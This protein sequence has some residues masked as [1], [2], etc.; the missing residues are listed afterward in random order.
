MTPE[1]E[2]KLAALKGAYPAALAALYRIGLI[3]K[4]PTAA[5]R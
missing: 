1:Q 3:A 5:G 2:E 4:R